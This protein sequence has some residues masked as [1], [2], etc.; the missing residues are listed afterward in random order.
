[1][2]SLDVESLFTNISLEETI[3]ISCD[4]LSDNEAEIKNF[5]RNDFEKLLRMAIKTTSLILMIKSI[6]KRMG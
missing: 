2:A 4:S 1:M 3:K 5:S 6:N